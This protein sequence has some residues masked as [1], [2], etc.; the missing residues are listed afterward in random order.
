MFTSG[1][2]RYAFAMEAKR[3][4]RHFGQDQNTRQH[5]PTQQHCSGVASSPDIMGI[6]EAAP[7]PLDADHLAEDLRQ[8]Q[9]LLVPGHHHMLAC[10]DAV[11]Q[12]KP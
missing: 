10:L 7:D 6:I 1:S 12:G 5:L 4:T 11:K 3:L 9:T 8:A 2:L